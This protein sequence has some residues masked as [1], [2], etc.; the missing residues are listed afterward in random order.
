MS[1][2]QCISEGDIKRLFL[3]LIFHQW[4]GDIS[5]RFF[6]KPRFNKTWF[7]QGPSGCVSSGLVGFVTGVS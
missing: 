4:Y 3:E 5:Q 2:S 1:V 7:R 6:T